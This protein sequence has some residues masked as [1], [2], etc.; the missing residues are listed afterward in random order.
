MRNRAVRADQDDGDRPLCALEAATQ[1]VSDTCKPV[2]LGDNDGGA[3]EL[4]GQIEDAK[5]G[6]RLEK[7]ASA[8][9]ARR[10]QRRCSGFEDDSHAFL[11]RATDLLVGLE[12]QDL[13]V[14]GRGNDV[15]QADLNNSPA[16][17]QLDGEARHPAGIPRMN[18]N[19]ESVQGKA[20][21]MAM[22]IWGC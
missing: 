3:V 18:G 6:L 13:A 14:M 5:H 16:S 19:Q 10:L 4:F 21:G 8:R 12:A 7:I 1:P 2:G 15:K 20:A 17:G 9:D 22:I 11:D